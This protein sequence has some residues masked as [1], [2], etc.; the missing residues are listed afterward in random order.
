[1]SPS[2]TPAKNRQR[3]WDGWVCGF[4]PCIECTACF[5]VPFQVNRKLEEFVI[6]KKEAKAAKIREEREL[7]TA[8]IKERVRA[9]KEQVT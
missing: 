9:E 1:M 8:R 3:R 2:S 5:S 6:A 4:I 7:A